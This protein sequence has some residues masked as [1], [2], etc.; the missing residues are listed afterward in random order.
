MGKSTAKRKTSVS[1]AYQYILNKIINGELLPGTPLREVHLAAE[2]DLSPTPVREA[3]RCL[4]YEGWLQSIPFRGRVVRYFTS[5][6][7]QGS[8]LLRE[9][10]E[11]VAVSHFI[12]NAPP[13]IWEEMRQILVK[14]EKYPA[15]CSEPLRNEFRKLD[16]RF[17]E[18]LLL[19][20]DVPT[21]TELHAR[22]RTQLKVL[23]RGDGGATAPEIHREHTMI[24]EA[25]KS[26]LIPIAEGILRHHIQTALQ[27]CLCKDTVIKTTRNA[28]ARK[29]RHHR[30]PECP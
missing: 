19:G 29:H 16:L 1:I 11:C 13:E 25:L 3:M 10:I 14:E 17:H 27:R 5:E 9:G 22:I 12:R 4:E 30:S 7:V 2:F 28:D 26:R 21:L 15:E 8:F 6:N 20:A 18:L 23:Y 24:Y